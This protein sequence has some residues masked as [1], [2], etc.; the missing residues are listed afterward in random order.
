MMKQME[1]ITAATLP[2]TALTSSHGAFD[3]Q[4]MGPDR[5]KKY[6]DEEDYVQRNGQL[7]LGVRSGVVW[8]VAYGCREGRDRIELRTESPPHLADQMHD[9]A[10]TAHLHELHHLYRARLANATEIVAAEID[11]HDVLGT[12]LLVGQQLGLQGE[13]GRLVDAARA[14][15]GDGPHGGAAPLHGHQHLRRGAG[16]GHPGQAQEVHVGRGVDH[17]QHPVDVE[18]VGGGRHREPLGRHHLEDVAGG[19]VLRRRLGTGDPRRAATDQTEDVDSGEGV[20]D[21]RRYR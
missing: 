21:Q 3:K 19:D 8:S 20:L 14:G 7:R 11:Q 13:V 6:A 17:P 18:G 4:P 16:D 5:V 1:I 9:V 10:V 12:L 2:T 15:A